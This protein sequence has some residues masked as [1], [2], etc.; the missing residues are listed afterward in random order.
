MFYR[1]AFDALPLIGY[2]WTVFMGKL[3]VGRVH[4]MR[5]NT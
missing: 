4:A 5:E 2:T 3:E 1:V